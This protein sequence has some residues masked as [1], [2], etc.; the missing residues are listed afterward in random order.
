MSCSAIP[1]ILVSVLARLTAA[2]P[3]RARTTFLDLLLGA[4]VTK[5]G[6]V[7]D[8]ILAAG[9]S[10]GWRTYYYPNHGYNYG[11]FC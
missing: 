2:V 7:S 11:I 5:S 1:P 9:L 4:V 10:R 6:H 8:A 3:A